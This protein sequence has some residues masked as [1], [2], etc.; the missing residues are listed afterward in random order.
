MKRNKFFWLNLIAMVAVVAALIYGVLKGLDSYTRH[1]EAVVVPHAKGMN[2]EE[3]EKL[4]MNHRLHAVVTDSTY[5][6][7]QPAGCVL[8]YQPQAGQK[9]KQ[10]RIIYLTVN[11]SNIP[12][13]AVPD[14]ADNSSYRQAAARILAGGFKL[15]SVQYVTGERDWVYGVKYRGQ[16]LQIG[17]KVPM[18]AILTLMV[19]NGDGE[20][21]PEDSL[22]LNPEGMP[23][24]TVEP[25]ASQGGSA[26][27]ES[28]FQ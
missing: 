25:A 11:T 20:G 13:Q 7:D 12:L 19:G 2:I 14:V 21:L 1:G 4:F 27:D 8:E 22:G 16:E 23:V 24:E 17:D 28:W 5:V 10:G 18:G 26:A 6:K 15:D 9:V 3:A